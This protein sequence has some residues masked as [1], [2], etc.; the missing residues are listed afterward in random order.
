MRS[1]GILMHLT[2]LPGGHGIGSMGKCA[3]AFVDYLKSAGQ[4]YWQILPLCPTGYGNSPYQCFSTFAGNHFLIDLDL[5]VEEGLL[6]TQ[7]TEAIHWGDRE[8]FVDFGLQHQHRTKLLHLAFA[9]DYMNLS[10]QEGYVWGTIRTA[11]ASVSD[12]CIV[13]MQ[14]LLDLGGEGRMNLPGSLSDDNWTWRATPK[15]ISP[16]LARK[17]RKLTELYGRLD[18]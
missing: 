1:S 3:Y 5:L 16:E 11:F 12:L 15:Q 7:E 2:S 8:D 17:L 13:P 14:D 18:G 10:D 6:T 9:R 4:R